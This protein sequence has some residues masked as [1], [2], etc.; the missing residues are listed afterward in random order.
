[1]TRSAAA[2]HPRIWQRRLEVA[3]A[4]GRRHRWAIG[5]VGAVVAVGALVVGLLH[6]GPFEARHR[7]LHGAHHVSAAAVWRAAG[8]SSSTPL[9]D[10]SPAAAERRIE[11][12]PW[13]ATAKVQRRWPDTV[14]VSVTERVP[15]AIVGSG[16]SA[17][18]VDRTGRVLTTVA[19]DPSSASLP[20]VASAAGPVAPGSTVGAA[21]R[22]GLAV[23]A[24]VPSTLAGQVRTIA[25]GSNGWVTAT[26][27]SGVGVAFGPAAELRA[28]FESL[29]AVLAD[30]TSDPTGPAVI[31]V[32][33]PEEP[34]V[35]PAPTGSSGPGS[36]GPG[37]SA[38]AAKASPATAGSGARG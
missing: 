18:V 4:R 32:T 36:S 8:V 14:V 30:P 5:G 26:L 25:V 11:A 34:T 12:L 38:T 21:A 7:L 16:P 22:P 17:A 31:D 24:A 9:V 3:R 13:V 35:G 19:A 27:A 10:I 20:T 23:A 28:K 2:P 33:D 15:V 29:A 1:M 6:A 37:S